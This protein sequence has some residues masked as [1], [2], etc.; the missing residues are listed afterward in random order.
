MKKFLALLFTAVA[1]C[2]GLL[3]A[4]GETVRNEETDLVIQA[5][6]GGYGVAGIQ[7]VADR[8]VE[9]NADKGYTVTVTPNANMVYKGVYDQIRMGP[10]LEPSDMFIAGLNYKTVVYEGDTFVQQDWEGE[11]A[12]ADL[13][14]VYASKVYGEDTLFRDKINVSYLENNEMNG[15]YYAASWASGV[16]GIMYNRTHFENNGWETPVTTNELNELCEKMKAK[17]FYPFEWAGGASYWEYCALPW[18][19]RT[20][21]GHAGC[22]KNLHD[23]YRRLG[24]KRDEKH[25]RDGQRGAL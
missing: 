17:G 5:Y 14:D 3:G 1:A 22:E 15:K 21:G 19:R 18:W 16:A 23:A 25:R 6:L 9:I 8:F 10:N 7:A 20:D 24:G 12:L 13:S 4:C 11:V 2:T